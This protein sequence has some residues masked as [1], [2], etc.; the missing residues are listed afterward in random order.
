MRRIGR[1]DGLRTYSNDPELVDSKRNE[2]VEKATKIFVK[3]G[4]HEV[5]MRELAKAVNMSVGTIY[6]YIGSKQD[7]LYLII[8]KFMSRPETWMD[9]IKKLA[10]S[11]GPV[12]ALKQF[13][14]DYY[15]YV[16]RVHNTTLFAYQET[17]SLDPK[18][19][20]AIMEASTQDIEVCAEILRIGVESGAFKIDNTLL[21]AHNIVVLGHVWAVRWWQ[22]RNTCTLDEYIEEQTGLI[23]SRI[24][25][26][27]YLVEQK[28]GN[29]S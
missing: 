24:S 3:K 1:K 12:N 22:L 25:S 29:K 2:I 9:D 13:I 4:Y 21:M 11:E 20:N 7:I 15:T 26:D 6:H 27:K 14:R 28:V 10:A 5:N 17:R 16:D 18:F 23:L 19:Q 8:N